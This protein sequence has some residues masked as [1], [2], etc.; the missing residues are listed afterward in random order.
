MNFYSPIS[1]KSFVN[2]LFSL[3][4]NY[5]LRSTIKFA[6]RYCPPR[7]IPIYLSLFYLRYVYATIKTWLPMGLRVPVPR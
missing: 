6:R 2:G 3:K 1:P 5:Q 7:L 4:S